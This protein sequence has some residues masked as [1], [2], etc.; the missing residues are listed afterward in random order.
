MNPLTILCSEVD[1]VVIRTSVSP[2]NSQQGCV[3][4]LLDFCGADDSGGGYFAADFQGWDPVPMCDYGGVWEISFCGLDAGQYQYKFLNGPGGWEFNG[5][6]DVCTNPADNENRFVDV[7]GGCD[8]EGP[9]CWSQCVAGSGSPSDTEP[10]MIVGDLPEDITISCSDDLPEMEVL[11]AE[12]ECSYDCTSEF[13]TDDDSGLD[14]CGLG[15]IIRTW[16]VFDCAGNEGTPYSQI[17]FIQDFEGP[18]ILDAPDDVTIACGTPLPP[19]VELEAEDEC[20]INVFETLIPTDDISNLNGDGTGEL[21]RSWYVEDC[22]GNFTEYDQ[23]ITLLPLTTEFQIFDACSDSVLLVTSEYDN[24]TWEFIDSMGVATD[25]NVNNDSIRVGETGIYRLTVQQGLCSAT[26]RDTILVRDPIEYTLSEGAVCSESFSGN[27]VI[28]LLGLIEFD[29]EDSVSI[30][31]IN[32]NELPDLVID[33]D[34]QMVGL[35]AFIVE[36]F[37]D[38]SCPPVLDTLYV[39]VVDCNCPAIEDIGVVCLTNEPDTIDLGEFLPQGLTGF[40]TVDPV[41]PAIIFN[42]DSLIINPDAE[43]LTYILTFTFDDSDINDNCSN[44]VP[45]PNE[46]VLTLVEQNSVELAE[47]ISVCNQP[48]T[49][50]QPTQVDLDSLVITNSMAGV[51]ISNNP[52]V[53]IDQDNLVDF[54]NVPPDTYVFI[55]ENTFQPGNCPPSV[56][57]IS[58][59]VFDCACPP[60]AVIQ[61]SLICNNSSINLSDFEIAGV[62]TWQYLNDGPDPSATLENGQTFNSD[63]LASGDY[64]FEFTLVEPAMDAGCASSL[65]TTIEVVTTPEAEI[66]I[67]DIFVCNEANNENIPLFLNLEFLLSANTDPGIWSAPTFTGDLSDPTNVSFQGIMSGSYLFTYQTI[68][69][70]N[71]GLP[72]NDAEASLTITVEECGCPELPDVILA[73]MICSEDGPVDLTPINSGVPEGIWTL[74]DDS[75]NETVVGVNSFDPSGFP[76]GEYTLMYTFDSSEVPFVCLDEAVIYNFELF[77]APVI[78]LPP[79]MTICDRENSSQGSS[80]IDFTLID[81]GVDGSW[82][83]PANYTEDFSDLS[84]VS[85]VGL[86]GESFVFTYMSNDPAN[87]CPDVSADFIVQVIDC[88]CPILAI[89]P[90]SDLCTGDMVIEL[91]DYVGAGTVSGIW[92]LQDESGQSIALSDNL[93]DPDLLEA[94]I[95]TAVYSV[96]E[97]VPAG[98][99]EI[100]N[101]E[102]EIFQ[103]PRAGMDNSDAFCFDDNS[104]VF[105]NDY[106]IDADAN[107]DWTQLSGETVLINSTDPIINISVLNPG[108]YTFNYN[109]EGEGPCEDDDSVME[110]EILD[111]PPIDAGPDLVIGCNTTEVTLGEGLIPDGTLIYNWFD[112]DNNPLTGN[113]TTVVVNSAGIYTLEIMDMNTGCSNSDILE[114]TEDQSFPQFLVAGIDP[115]CSDLQSGTISL[116][117][118][119]G[120]N[121]D[122]NIEITGPIDLDTVSIAGAPVQLINLSAGVYTFTVESDGCEASQ[123]IY[124]LISPNTFEIDAG[125]MI[126]TFQL[127]QSILLSVEF[128]GIS[129]EEIQSLK[130]LSATGELL[131]NGDATTCQTFTYSTDIEETIIIEA[132]S[133]EG[134]LAVDTILLRPIESVNIYIPNILNPRAF[135]ENTSLRVYSNGVVTELMEYIVYDRWGNIVYQDLDGKSLIDPNETWWN[136]ST[137]GYEV[138]Q[139]VYVVLITYRNPEDSGQTI[140]SAHSVTVLN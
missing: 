61:D 125:P 38:R 1:N 135:D 118:F 28:D 32:G 18:E 52:L 86:T 130:W 24:Y 39:N 60:I 92:T 53:S 44:Q 78:N 107:G 55:F 112:S 91:E 8:I 21:I 10:P 97:I 65:I 56:D 79:D 85:F 48:G 110:L 25:L 13:P 6:G 15:E 42:G 139:G 122:Y 19:S 51:W 26:F 116:G 120:G 117:Q 4:F 68:I 9:W 58:V 70:Q 88:S 71:L 140:S 103:L 83:A 69:A 72:C 73:S 131:C 134:C 136:G 11:E 66:V 31:N 111:L 126:Q 124:E 109:V 82:A 7:S 90:I 46:S 80:F 37:G 89:N 12:D 45:A 76:E 41:D 133:E 2:G 23:I 93:V 84:N 16:Q 64:S 114:V 121:G 59:E 63:G 35:V 14:A 57:S 3:T 87:P 67:Q 30:S 29:S 47:D 74:I 99:A 100:V 62:G 34:G 104:Q 5:F 40:W 128:Q 98:C 129:S 77:S 22:R 75:G 49:G 27:S 96:T 17:I 81:P 119:S 94:G 108:L 20:D 138:T 106:L 102:F 123:V 36:I 54:N 105:L 50:A 113:G 115:V 127:G 43:I 101:V 132:L 95:Y 33:F 137:D